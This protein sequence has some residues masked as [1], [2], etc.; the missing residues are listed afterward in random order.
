MKADRTLDCVGTYCP[1]PLVRT[2]AQLKEMNVGEVL[3]VLTD[4]KRAKLDIPD[5]CGRTGHELQGV[6]VN[7]GEMR[8][9][10]KK[11]HD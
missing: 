8:I 1:T 5:W 9:Y 2:G 4:D 10:I 7:S 3:E 6:E 11:A